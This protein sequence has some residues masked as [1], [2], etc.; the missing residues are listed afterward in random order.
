MCYID[1]VVRLI[2][3]LMMKLLLNLWFLCVR[4]MKVL[5]K[6]CLGTCT[7]RICLDLVEMTASW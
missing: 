7:M 6:M 3:V 5:L 4:D 1:L 2:A